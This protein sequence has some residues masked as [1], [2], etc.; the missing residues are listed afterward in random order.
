MNIST[1]LISILLANLAHLS[2]QQSVDNMSQCS[3]LSNRDNG[4]APLQLS[5]CP[6]QNS[7]VSTTGECC[8]LCQLNAQCRSW[9]FARK[10]NTN[11]GTC[12]LKSN[13]GQ[14][15]SCPGSF[16]GIINQPFSQTTN[17]FP[18]ITFATLTTTTTTTTATTTTTPTTVTQPTTGATVTR[19]AVC[20]DQ[21]DT[22]FPGNDLTN[23]GNIVA[24]PNVPTYTDCC[25]ICAANPSCTAYSFLNST[26]FCWL[27]NGPVAP[28][29]DG[30]P[31]Y[32]GVAEIY[33][34]IISGPIV[35]RR[36][37]MF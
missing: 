16:T 26:L 32:N 37:R 28:G 23:N 35:Q 20:N 25:N 33:P 4:G 12:I 15:F 29:P 30:T 10:L 14:I 1:L 24:F 11:S 21:L 22:N 5:V 19:L 6:Q 3:F 31:I 17:L 18:T 34:G 9:T 7:I 8:L 13:V 2:H 36:K 27:K